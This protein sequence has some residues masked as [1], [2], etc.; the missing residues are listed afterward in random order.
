MGWDC[1]RCGRRRWR[2]GAE[3]VKRVSG[4]DEKK[5]EMRWGKN[6]GETSGKERTCRRKTSDDAAATKRNEITAGQRMK[7]RRD[8]KEGGTDGR[9][10]GCSA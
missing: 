9:D 3:E 4:D 5:R 6:T 10:R 8:E 2:A 7:G 1:R